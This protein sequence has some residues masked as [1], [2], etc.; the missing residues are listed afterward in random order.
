MA[1]FVVFDLGGV[2]IDWNPRYL[3]RQLLEPQEVER[4]IQDVVPPDWN[5][6]MDAGK[7]FAEAI[8]ERVEIFPQHSSLIRAYYD[9][10]DEMLGGSIQG[11][12][13]LLYRLRERDVPLF[14]LTNWSAETFRFAEE[15]FSFL[16][17]FRDI[18]VSGR[19]R[20]KKPNP[21]IYRIL[22]ARN[23][24]NPEVGIFID[25]TLPNVHAAEGVGLSAIHFRSP[26]GLEERLHELRVL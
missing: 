6:Q 26:D 13:D 14:A 25:D 4:F 18:V 15:R 5:E 2:L 9:R 7:P 8:R 20:V 19:E 10:W 23:G 3:F 22:L 21:E 12:V 1:R 16:S 24:L 17:C 11:T